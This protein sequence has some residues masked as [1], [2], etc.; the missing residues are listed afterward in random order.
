MLTGNT[1]NCTIPKAILNKTIFAT[2]SGFMIE[3]SQITTSDDITEGQI[4]HLPEI[5]STILSDSPSRI[6][7][8][9]SQVLEL[10]AKV[11]QDIQLLRCEE[12]CKMSEV[13]GLSKAQVK[14]I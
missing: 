13:C 4:L 6:A 1:L 9:T 11:D 3:E 2:I 12:M 7:V 8:G 10:A 14:Q 5:D